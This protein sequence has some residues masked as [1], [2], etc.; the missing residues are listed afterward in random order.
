[1]IHRRV[2]AY[3]E[4]EKGPALRK[5]TKLERRAVSGLQLLVRRTKKYITQSKNLFKIDFFVGNFID[6]FL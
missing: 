1:M 2:Q 4:E 6:L 5:T 3:I